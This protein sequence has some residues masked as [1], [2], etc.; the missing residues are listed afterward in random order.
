MINLIKYLFR[1]MAATTVV[2]LTVMFTFFIGIIMLGVIVAGFSESELDEGLIAQRE[3]IYGTETSSNELL[4]IDI[5]GLILGER[6]Y[7]DPWLAGFETGITYGYEVKDA[8]K[9]AAEDESIKGIL[10]RVNSPGGTIFGSHAILEGVEEYKLKTGKPVIAYVS[11]VAASGSYWAILDAD[12]IVADYGTTIGSIGIIFGP[13][14]YYDGVTS[15]DGG[16]FMG[17]VVTE[18]GIE[19]TYITAGRS[20]DLGNPYRQLSS[21]ETVRL[22]EMV[23]DQYL[24]FVNLVAAHRELEPEAVVNS[25][26]A[27]VYGE[28]AAN[29][30]GLIDQMGT[31]DQAILRL[32]EAAG[33]ADDFQVVEI[34]NDFGF[35]DA[36]LSAHF[37]ARISAPDSDK[38][39]QAQRQVCTLNS[40]LLAYHGDPQA[41]CQ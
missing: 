4:V 12:E 24:D 29:E 28:K 27:L 2:M 19:T 35:W 11:G 31:R 34:E 33:V 15:E 10:L 5:N 8:L 26:G 17:G 22:Q 32:A 39:T 36:F 7:S 40:T 37:L 9:E 3:H 23:N 16:I 20:K 41:L 13:F 25:I 21:E 14:K 18:R 38:M 30:L 6:E 1:I